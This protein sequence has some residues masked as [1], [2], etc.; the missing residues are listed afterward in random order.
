[1]QRFGGIMPCW[2]AGSEPSGGPWERGGVAIGDRPVMFL[3]ERQL[4]RS[5]EGLGGHCPL[6]AERTGVGEGTHLLQ[7]SRAGH[8]SS[9]EHMADTCWVWTVNHHSRGRNRCPV[10]L[11]GQ[12]PRLFSSP[13]Q[14]AGLSGDEARRAV[15]WEQPVCQAWPYAQFPAYCVLVI[16]INQ[17]TSQG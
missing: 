14:E 8:S 10:C 11:P 16:E 4:G 2:R 12:F 1:M 3:E 9:R 13:S 7:N 6:Q 17:S 5:P 15:T